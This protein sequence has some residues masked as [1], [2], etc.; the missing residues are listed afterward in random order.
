MLGPSHP[1]GIDGLP[2]GHPDHFPFHRAVQRKGDT[3]QA[4]RLTLT[5]ETLTRLDNQDAEHIQGG[6]PMA[7][8]ELRGCSQGG[9]I[10]TQNCPKS[11]GSGCC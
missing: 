1:L 2:R 5:R 9:G 11:S 4:K 6:M 10:C 3:M 7:Y 8:S